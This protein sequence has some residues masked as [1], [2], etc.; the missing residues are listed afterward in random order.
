M[1]KLIHGP[2]LKEVNPACNE[3]RIRGCGPLA[4]PRAGTEATRGGA[5]AGWPSRS[6]AALWQRKTRMGPT[7]KIPGDRGSSGA[8]GKR[9]PQLGGIGESRER[10]PIWVTRRAVARI[11]FSDTTRPDLHVLPSGLLLHVISQINV[12]QKQNRFIRG[13]GIDDPNGVARSAK[14]VA[15]GLDRHGCIDIADDDVIGMPLA[16][17]A[18]L[19]GPCLR[20]LAAGPRR[21]DVRTH[22]RIIIGLTL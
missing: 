2:R 6:R 11:D 17:R 12:G 19:C 10:C 9:K 20:M 7:E 18:D 3:N 5:P 1:Q 13:N 22:D 8:P 14:N 21:H 4:L 16:K 15:L